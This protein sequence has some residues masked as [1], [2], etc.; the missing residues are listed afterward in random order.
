MINLFQP[1]V[2][3]ESLDLLS[4]VFESRWLGRGSL[5]SEFEKEINNFCGHEIRTLS[6]ASDAI[7]GIFQFLR[8]DKGS[9]VILPTNSFPAVLSAVLLNG[10]VPVIVDIEL[11]GNIDIN[12]VERAV[13]N[14]TVAVFVTHYGG[15]PVDIQRLRSSIPSRIKIFEDSACAFGT[16]TDKGH[17]GYDSDYSLYSFDA[18]KL[19][20]CGEGG[21]YFSTNEDLFE[22]LKSFYY[23]GLPAS[24]KSGLDSSKSNNEWWNYTLEREGVRSVFTNIN[25]AI[26]LPQVANLN[27]ALKRKKE[28]RNRYLSEVKSIEFIGQEF[29]GIRIHSNY[30]CTIKSAKRNE[31]AKFLLSRDVYSSLRYS[32]LGNM[33]QYKAYNFGDHSGAN[34]FYS[35]SL[36]IPIHHGLSDLD[37]EKIIDSLNEF[38]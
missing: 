15:T 1:V 8:F 4:N 11:D 31:L 25:A 10:L 14:K 37:V 16:F 12:E 38:N 5:V 30:F 21:G 32:P 9:E 20:T 18:M 22:G 13:N 2:G 34:K 19:L 3:K 28:I 6:C 7:F 27:F 24:E 29:P 17:V 26:G 35:Q 23:L 36:N 33:P